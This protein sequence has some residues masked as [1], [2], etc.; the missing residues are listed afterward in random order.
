MAKIIRDAF[1]DR[2]QRS[3]V[4]QNVLKDLQLGTGLRVDYY[5]AQPE[6]AGFA[7]PCRGQSQL[8]DQLNASGPHQGIC[9]RYCRRAFTEAR[10]Q[11]QI[12]PCIAQTQLCIAPLNATLGLMGYLVCGGYYPAPLQTRDIN[13]IRHLLDR[14][15]VDL[16][17]ANVLTTTCTTPILPM[18]RMQAISNLL[19][20]AAQYI[21]RTLSTEL[22]S[23]TKDLPPQIQKACRYIQ[24]NFAEDP[25]LI[26]TAAKVG[27][28]AP[29]LSRLFH[30]TTGLRFKEYV[31]EVRMQ[32]ARRMLRDGNERISEIAFAVGY[33]SLSQFNRQFLTHYQ[34]SPREFRRQFRPTAPCE[35]N[36]KPAELSL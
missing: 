24:A 5:P 23:E 8:C 25:T 10:T 3:Q 15:G 16:T 34:Q 14:E 2:V 1:A 12:Y 4:L 27:L 13:R 36:K 30:K 9:A 20:V 6:I 19:Q 7:P 22:F 35:Q 11:A 21:V 18:E 17:F 33:R 28:S 31:N 32:A 26:E 29:H